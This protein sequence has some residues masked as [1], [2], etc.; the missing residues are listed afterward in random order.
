MAL[1][2]KDKSKNRAYVAVSSVLILGFTRPIPGRSSI[3]SIEVK[4][5]FILVCLHPPRSPA[6]EEVCRST[7]NSQARRLSG[8]YPEYNAAASGRGI[9]GSTR[10]PLSAAL[11]S[12]F[13]E[14]G[15][16]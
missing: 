6:R 11:R 1:L 4:Q 15:T 3:G 8:K 10:H 13:R 16:D 7:D 14:R 12:L 2:G 5:N 9:N